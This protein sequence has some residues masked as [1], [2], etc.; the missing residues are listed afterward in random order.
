MSLIS[1]LVAIA[2]FGFIVWILTQIPMPAVVRN[3]IIGFA[4][5]FI[6]LYALQL[7]GVN[8]GLNLRLK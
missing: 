8:T 5:L 7:L 6:V 4:C 1:I 3:I 2:I